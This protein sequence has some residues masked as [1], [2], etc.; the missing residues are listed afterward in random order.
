MDPAQSTHRTRQRGRKICTDSI[1]RD[2]RR[3][4]SCIRSL[5]HVKHLAV[6]ITKTLSR[7]VQADSG[8]TVLEHYRCPATLY[9]AISTTMQHPGACF[10]VQLVR[11]ENMRTSVP[12]VYMPQQLVHTLYSRRCSCTPTVLSRFRSPVGGVGV[13]AIPS[14]LRNSKY[15]MKYA[16]LSSCMLL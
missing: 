4:A 5:T 8:E 16:P 1:Y 10:P 15:E 11:S 3:Y 12:Y 13:R 6:L 2:L 14:T 9:L 7:H